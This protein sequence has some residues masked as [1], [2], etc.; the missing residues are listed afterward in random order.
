[1]VVQRGLNQARL[2]YGCF[3][4]P[5]TMRLML[6]RV[7]CAAGRDILTDERLSDFSFGPHGTP[8][9]RA[10]SPSPMGSS[11]WMPNTKPSEF[12]S[13]DV[14]RVSKTFPLSFKRISKE[15][16]IHEL[17]RSKRTDPER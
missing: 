3:F 14:S 17:L 16:C 15:S 12:A 1:V 2:Q 11:D 8:Q 4:L 13:N 9:R 5:E 7:P 6:Q 10:A